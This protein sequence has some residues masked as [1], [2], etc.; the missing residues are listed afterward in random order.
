MDLIFVLSV[1]LCPNIFGKEDGREPVSKQKA[2][3]FNL[4]HCKYIAELDNDNVR[5]TCVENTH[6]KTQILL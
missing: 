4:L 6:L 3:S 2:N 5:C 1:T